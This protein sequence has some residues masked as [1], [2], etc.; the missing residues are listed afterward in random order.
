MNL[1]YILNDPD[2]PTFYNHRYF[3]EKFARGFALLGFDVKVANSVEEVDENS[4]VMI[5]KH[6]LERGNFSPF[7]MTK[8]QEV[9]LGKDRII[10]FLGNLMANPGLLRLY[11]RAPST[12]REKAIKVLR[13]LSQK[14][15]I[16]LAWGY[17]KYKDLLD[18]L[19]MKYIIVGPF[20]YKKP[21]PESPEITKLWYKI[22][23]KGGNREMRAF[24]I[25]F[26]AA[27]DPSEVGKDCNNRDI[28][29][30]YIGNRSYG[31][32]YYR[33]FLN[34]PDCKI[35]PTPPYI[36]EEERIKI[37]KNSMICLGLQKEIA[38]TMV[39]ERIFESLAYG[40]I[41]LS[42]HRLASEVT[43]GI[44]KFIKN[45][46]HLLQLVEYYV[47]D[48]DERLK[49]RE[50]GFKFIRNGHTYKHEAQKILNFIEKI[51]NVR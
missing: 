36:S 17:Y 27:V 50:K 10:G 42:N 38:T 35:I 15:A 8:K 49:L 51:Y 39:T 30:C 16:V 14:N 28:K 43:K 1:F 47:S 37:L 48:E 29:V 7:R 2:L 33:L 31:A 26:A 46:D 25:K 4:I 3:V 12:N 45:K 9:K 11:L 23:K 5:S 40:S 44:V 19:N 20:Y 41:C 22:T 21:P 34:R 18:E 32:E 6:A 13:K 24:P